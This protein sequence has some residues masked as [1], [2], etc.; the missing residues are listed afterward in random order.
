M[1]PFVLH[2]LCLDYVS[3]LHILR[4]SQKDLTECSYA[5]ALVLHWIDVQILYVLY[6]TSQSGFEVC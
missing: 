6:V 3:I 2:C 5:A 4:G 1:V